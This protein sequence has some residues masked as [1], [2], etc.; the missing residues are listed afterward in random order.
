LNI[1]SATVSVI[2]PTYNYAEFLPDALDSVFGQTFADWEAIVIDDGSTDNTREVIQ[3]YL[4]DGRVRYHRTNHIG[5]SAARNLG[6]SLATS[7]LI[8]FLDADD[9]WLPEKLERQVG[10][11]RSDPDLGVT[12]TGQILVDEHGWLLET[13]PR[14]LYRGHVLPQVFCENFV[15]F[16]SSM[17]RR[18]VIDD[19]GPFDEEIQLAIDYEFWLRAARRYRFDYVDEPLT[20]YRTGHAS[21]SKRG[22]ERRFVALHIR[23]RFLDEYGGRRLLDAG[24][25]RRGFSHLYMHIALAERDRHR[26]KALAWYLRAIA[27]SPTYYA[28]W[29]GFASVLLPDAF[30]RCIRRVRGRPADWNSMPRRVS[31]SGQPI[32]ATHLRHVVPQTKGI[33]VSR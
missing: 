5:A 10:L 11:F 31:A 24:V 21:I 16:S 30:R 13:K 29:R 6:I 9:L 22:H 2:I 25:V 18:A 3:P 28:A 17:V 19:V 33:C 15:C 8:A 32:S 23:R 20:L 1:V 14:K 7:P 26:L 4:N 12:C 27:T